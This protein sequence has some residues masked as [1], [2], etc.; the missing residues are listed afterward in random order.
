[1][2]QCCI[3]QCRP[4]ELVNEATDTVQLGDN[5]TIINTDPCRGHKN[6]SYRMYH[7]DHHTGSLKMI[8][9]S[10]SYT[11]TIHVQLDTSGVYCVHKEC[12]TAGIDACCVQIQIQQKLMIVMSNVT[13]EGSDESAVCYATGWPRPKHLQIHSQDSCAIITDDVRV[14]DHYSTA[15]FFTFKAN[16]SCEWI[17][18][19]TT[20]RRI[21]KEIQIIQ[22]SATGVQ[23]STPSLSSTCSGTLA[24]CRTT[25]W[26]II[27]V[28]SVI[29]VII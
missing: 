27:L 16:S 21:T 5:Y 6:M 24:M 23:S 14:I 7:Q 15:V 1:M 17:S 29:A 28:L 25:L 3:V 13:I 18:C 19:Q 11:H 10:T 20:S 2:L 26:I 4:L 22:N 8:T 12:S 9:N